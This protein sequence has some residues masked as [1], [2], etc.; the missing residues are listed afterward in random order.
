MNP[1][2]PPDGSAHGAGIDRLLLILHLFMAVVFT[3]WFAYFVATLVRYRA[4]KRPAAS[5]R[6]PRGLFLAATVALVLVVELVLDL[7][8]SVPI[9]S[10]RSAEFPDEKDATVVRVV[11][12]QFA[13]NVHYPG[14]DGR[15]GRTSADLVEPFNPLGLDRADPAARDDI[16]LLNRMVVPA[17]KPVIVYLTSKDV[18]HSF[19]LPVYRVKQDAVPGLMSPVWFVPEKTTAQIREEM[20]T[21]FSVRKAVATRR[22]IAL[23]PLETLDLSGGK[24]PSGYIAAADIPDSG[25]STLLSAGDELDEAGVAS[26]LGAGVTTVRARRKAGLDME[27]SAREYLDGSGASV[28]AAHEGLGEDAVTA[29]VNAGIRE[30]E[31][32]RKSHTDP[33]IV[34]FAIVAPGGDTLAPA[35]TPLDEEIISKAAAAGIESIDVAPA[36]PTEIACAQLCGLGHY[37]MRGAMDV[38]E[39]G[40]YRKW[41][42]EQEAAANPGDQGTP[43]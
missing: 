19:N 7:F 39:P 38:L 16:T 30:V 31:A 26:L 20:A 11:A 22:M 21:T 14:P 3:A 10:K 13:W 2:L 15:F 1:F 34:R 4:A 33:W 36:T 17:G 24:A 32:R 8:F 18:I 12:E 41:F 25:G 40:E 9:W 27:I 37:Q 42:D 28:L 6:G 23:P 5:Y 29:L 43:Q 35:G